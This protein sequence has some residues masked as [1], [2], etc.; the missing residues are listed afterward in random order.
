MSSVSE[1]T[2][3]LGVVLGL[4]DSILEGPGD[5]AYSVLPRPWAQ[6]LAVALDVPYHGVAIP[7][8]TAPELLREGLPRVAGRRYGLA[9]VGIGTN[10][11]RDPGWDASRYRAA[12]AQLLDGID[13]E[14]TCVATVPHDLG[15]PRA[16][17][18]VSELGRIIRDEAR[19]REAV[20]VDLDD[21]HGWRLVMPDAVHPTALGQVEIADRAARALGL[22]VLPSSLVEIRGGDVRHAVTR[23]A[24]MVVRDWRRRVQDRS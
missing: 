1:I 17:A 24:P 19:A 3:G 16:G 4:G 7:G 5:G 14:R 21:L 15:R 12:L 13:A 18:K 22:D 23:H 20:V 10:D 11:V 2:S 8:I 9:C 6:W